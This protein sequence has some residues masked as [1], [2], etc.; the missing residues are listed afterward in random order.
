MCFVI[1]CTSRHKSTP[2]YKGTCNQF[3]F[4]LI[5]KNKDQL[6]ICDKSDGSSMSVFSSTIFQKLP[7]PLFLGIST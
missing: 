3:G 5:L 2:Y 6:S 7:K 1:S 4:G